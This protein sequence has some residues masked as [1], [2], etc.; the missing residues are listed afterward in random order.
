MV[1]EACQKQSGLLKEV[2]IN[3][4]RAFRT[5]L[6]EF[7]QDICKQ[8][9]LEKYEK[10]IDKLHKVRPKGQLYKKRYVGKYCSCDKAYQSL[11]LEDL[12][13]RSYLEKLTTDD[14]CVCK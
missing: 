12:I 1:N 3:K 8:D 14:K 4:I 2:E 6:W 13:C 9:K 11:A 7:Q 10:V 5:E